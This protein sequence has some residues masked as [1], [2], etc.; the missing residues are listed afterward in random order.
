MLTEQDLKRTLWHSR[1]GMLEL[2]LILLPF[3][4]ERLAQLDAD[5]QSLYRDLLREEDQDLFA[6]FIHREQAPLPL[7]PIVELIV[8]LH[9]EAGDQ[10]RAQQQAGTLD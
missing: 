7:R 8:R 2:D 10:R 1:R 6:W 4:T 5:L 3:A 9:A